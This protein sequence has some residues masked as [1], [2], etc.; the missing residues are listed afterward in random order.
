MLAKLTTAHFDG[1]SP[2]NSFLTPAASDEALKLAVTLFKR[3]NKD[4][5]MCDT[6]REVRTAGF[7]VYTPNT[8]PKPTPAPETEKEIK[9]GREYVFNDED[10]KLFQYTKNGKDLADA[11]QKVDY[12]K[13]RK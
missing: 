6:V 4:D 3:L 1:T 12:D 5:T 9:I 10:R 13:L 8:L 11:K 7:A 2:S